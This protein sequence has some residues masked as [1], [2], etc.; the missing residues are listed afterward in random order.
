MDLYALQHALENHT[1]NDFNEWLDAN[2]KELSNFFYKLSGKDLH[3][4][5]FD[6]FYYG[7]IAKSN[8]YQEYQSNR[9]PAESFSLFL[10][11]ISV[12]AEKLALIGIDSLLHTLIVDLPETASRFRLAAINEFSSVEDISTD[13]FTKLPVVLGLLTQ[14]QVIDDD[15]NTRALVDILT[16]YYKKAVSK[17]EEKGLNGYDSKLKGIFTDQDLADKYPLLTHPVI[18]DVVRGKEPFSIDFIEV[19]RDRLESSDAIRKL[20]T[21]INGEYFGHPDIDHN[22]GRWWSY[23]KSNILFDILVRG[24]A[25]FTTAYGIISPQEKVLLYCFFNMKKHFFTSYAVFERIIPSLKDFFS[26]DDYRPVMID[27]GCGPMTSGLAM[28]DLINTTM[29][30][31]ISFSYVGIDISTAML[32][33]AKTFEDSELFANCTFNYFESWNNID[34]GLLRS[35]AGTNNPI[36]FNASYLFASDSLLPSDL[37]DYITNVT[38]LYENV[39]LIFQNPSSEARNKKYL[40]FKEFIKF[41]KILDG[42]ED[43]R[44]VA[45]SSESNEVVYYEI[46]KFLR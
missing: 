19:I 36:I 20:F 27:L 38:K 35:I 28:A 31:A 26:N 8:A 18:E 34:F 25:D 10:D 32:D 43:I 45:A 29:G 39:Y 44:Y 15:G 11:M 17:F 13:Y 21:Q 42:E 9:N 3:E 33:R 2:E 7:I 30:R 46:L 41:E 14:A 24:R 6:N 12:S 37:A 40:E 23:N 5:N 22:R 1:A 4:L 16:F